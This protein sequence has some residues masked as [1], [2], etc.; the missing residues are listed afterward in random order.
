MMS[1]T[2]LTP[3]EILSLEKTSFCLTK[4]SFPPRNIFKF[5]P[6]SIESDDQHQ[7]P[8]LGARQTPSKHYGKLVRQS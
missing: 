8:P 7:E 3:T 1:S 2:N 5:L 4:H 6:S